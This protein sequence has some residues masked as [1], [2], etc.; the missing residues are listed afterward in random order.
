[1][2]D[3]AIAIRPLAFVSL[4]FDHRILDGKAAD[5]FMVTFKDALEDWH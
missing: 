3:E 4:T 1:V 2:I 5:D